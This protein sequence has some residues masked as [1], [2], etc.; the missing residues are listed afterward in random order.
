MKNYRSLLEFNLGL[1]PLTILIGRNDAGKSNL[2]R[3]LQLLLDDEAT[4]EVDQQYDWS[5]SDTTKRF[6]R[7]T[8][9]EA[10]LCHNAGEQPVKII[11]KINI[12]KEANPTS[13]QK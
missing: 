4:K 7:E 11:R 2:L 5:R 12:P 6:P 10:E 3:S 13:V 9:I 8:F 1:Q